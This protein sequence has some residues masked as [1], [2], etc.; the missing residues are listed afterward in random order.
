M[1]IVADRII[2]INN[3]CFVVSCNEKPTHAYNMIMINDCILGC[4]E[5][6]KRFRYPEYK[7]NIISVLP[8]AA[9]EAI[10]AFKTENIPL[11]KP[12][13]TQPMTQSMSTANVE[14]IVLYRPVGGLEHHLIRQSGNKRF[15]TRLAHQ[16]IFYPV[17][18][19]EYATQIARYW[20]TKDKD[21]GS[22]G[23]V[24]RF[25]IV[26]S[27]IQSYDIHIV[28]GVKHQE[29]WIP[30]EDLEEFN[31]NIV[32]EIETVKVFYG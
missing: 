4:E 21:N 20:N 13:K 18:D 9:T 26:R 19:E 29:Y 25:K 3:G 12:S 22:V 15:P 16:P 10:P 28:G 7:G 31:D 1:K 32:G 30:A 24:L 27:F 14:T 23:F 11:F 5:H 17:L 2:I 8:F 6:I